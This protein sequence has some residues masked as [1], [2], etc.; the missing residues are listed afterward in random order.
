VLGIALMLL[1]LAGSAE[2]DAVGSVSPYSH[3]FESPE[4][5]A[6]QV[7]EH[8][9]HKRLDDLKPLALSEQEFKELVWPE[10]PAAR[11]ERNV[12]VEYA[13]GSLHQKSRNALAWT[14]HNYGGRRFELV[15][16]V[17]DGETT[18]YET[19]TVH[20]EGRCVVR[21]EDS[22]EHKLAL[23]GSVL[24]HEGRYKLFSFV[25]D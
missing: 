16:V 7:L 2:P 12:P 13:W 18:Q 6:A 9:E 10:M 25:N 19:F 17:F 1:P 8:L 24:V 15:R 4:A 3:T 23:F 14:V 5:L 22:R 21:D 20:R 11:P